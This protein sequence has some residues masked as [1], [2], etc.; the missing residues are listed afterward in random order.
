MTVCGIVSQAKHVRSGLKQF[1]HHFLSVIPTKAFQ[2][3]RRNLL[4]WHGQQGWAIAGFSTPGLRPP[5]EMT[6]VGTNPDKASSLITDTCDLCTRAFL[7]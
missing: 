7:I 5:V 6:A 3:A 4:S 2:A 1:H